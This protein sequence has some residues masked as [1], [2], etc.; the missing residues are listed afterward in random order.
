MKI[1]E[2]LYIHMGYSKCMSTWLQEL[3]ERHAEIHF[4]LKSRF[5]Q[6]YRCNFEKGLDYYRTII[7]KGDH[8]LAVE[9]DEHLLMS[10]VDEQLFI[11]T[12]ELDYVGL[13]ARRIA[14]SIEKPKIIV[15]VR[16]QVDMIV[17]R[18]IQ[19]VRGG[20]K[21]TFQ[22]YFDETFL[23]GNYKKFYGYEYYQVIK[24]LSEHI[25]ID[26][27][28]IINLDDFKKNQIATLARLSGFMGIDLVKYGLPPRE[29]NVSPSYYA[30]K[31]QLLIN[32]LFV[33]RKNVSDERTK[34]RI[35]YY[36]YRIMMRAIEYLDGRLVRD[37]GKY[38]FFSPEQR[39]LIQQTYHEDNKKFGDL[40]GQDLS[41]YR[42]WL[43]HEA[44]SR[45]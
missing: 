6:L 21:L 33:T 40:I 45:V 2:N 7:S 44:G 34:C 12:A 24:R 38:R 32:R 19:F 28:F 4:V 31:L 29:A 22:S 9:S 5:F 27:I 13:M 14:E 37:K 25:N 43:G 10:A 41:K 42:F 35:N 15:V 16:N 30:V 11:H 18:Y 39:D 17:S 23:N 26:D 36:V 20:G 8:K 3:F 1:K